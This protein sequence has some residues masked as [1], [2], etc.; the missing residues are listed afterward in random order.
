MDFD[1]KPTIYIVT[2]NDKAF[3]RVAKALRDVGY[4]VHFPE[5]NQFEALL[6]HM[7]ERTAATVVDLDLESYDGLGFLRDI[8]KAYEK[9]KIRNEYRA[10]IIAVSEDD[11]LHHHAKDAG[12]E[13]FVSVQRGDEAIYRAILAADEDTDE[14][15]L[16]AAARYFPDQDHE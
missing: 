15:K 4:D 13:S 1:D 9:D 3:D 8:Q 6:T 12:A 11:D 14:L 2:Q 7:P 16:D 10:P 5:I